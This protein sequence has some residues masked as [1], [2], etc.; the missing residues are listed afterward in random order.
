MLRRIILLLALVAGAPA[1]AQSQKPVVAVIKIDDLTSSGQADTLSA[2]IESAIASTGKFRL[3]ER[4]QMGKLVG[5]QARGRGGMVT[6]NRPGKVGG[7]EGID[8]LVYGSITSLSSKSA[9]NIGSS[10]LAGMLSGKNGGTPNC[11]NTIATLA[12]DIKITD[13][14]SGEI[15]YVTRI[16]E[17]QKSAASCNGKGEIDSTALLRSAADRVATGLLT[18]IHP[19]QIAA[20]QGDGTVVLNYGQGAVQTGDVMAVF[21]KGLSIRDPST[22]EV[23]GN[24]ETR[25]GMIQI[26]SVLGRLSKATM[27]G[28]FTPA[29]GS[30]VRPVSETEARAALRPAKKRK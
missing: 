12:L 21:A 10:L 5:E 25:L 13:A 17:S 4:Q 6:T 15:K 2:M 30:I 20:V 1:A 29:V 23:I 18:S 7:F 19:I 22:G 24:D 9:T 8:Y 11:Q 3:F 28:A 27:I 16:D 14:D 26:S